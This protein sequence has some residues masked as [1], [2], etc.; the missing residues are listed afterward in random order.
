MNNE[1]CLRSNGEKQMGILFNLLAVEYVLSP[2]SKEIVNDN[3]IL[4]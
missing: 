2:Y 3:E 4:S 1:N